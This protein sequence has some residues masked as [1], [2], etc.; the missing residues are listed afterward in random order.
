MKET[1]TTQKRGIKVT[2]PLPN[3]AKPDVEIGTVQSAKDNKMMR[4]VEKAIKSKRK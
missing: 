4:Q 2:M 3:W 1:K